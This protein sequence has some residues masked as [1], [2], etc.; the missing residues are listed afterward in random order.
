MM[1]DAMTKKRAL[2][3]DSAPERTATGWQGVFIHLKVFT[4]GLNVGNIR[5]TMIMTKH[6]T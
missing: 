1:E 4:S 2:T 3:K 5:F 6:Q